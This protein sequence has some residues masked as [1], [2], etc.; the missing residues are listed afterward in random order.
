MK[1]AI[2]IF[3]VVVLI[4]TT[5]IYIRIEA[6]YDVI[7]NKGHLKLV[8]FKFLTIYNKDFEIIGLFIKLINKKGK[9]EMV[10]IDLQDKKLK[11]LADLQYY[12]I[13]KIYLLSFNSRLNIGNEDAIKTCVYYESATILNN[14]LFFKINKFEKDS[15]INMQ[16]F[17]TIAENKL[18]ISLKV[19]FMVSIFD[20]IYGVMQAFLEK[21]NF[22]YEE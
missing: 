20:L 9:I 15:S 7:N 11:F 12:I 17:P 13:H 4:I 22:I 18:N 10:K 16:I 8:L 1:N 3:L 21:G 2:I 6:R 5:R 19:E 14:I